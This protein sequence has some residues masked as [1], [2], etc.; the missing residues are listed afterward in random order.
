MINF[1]FTV[2]FLITFSNSNRQFTQKP[3][4][5]IMDMRESPKHPEPP[6]L[7]ELK[8]KEPTVIFLT[9]PLPRYNKIKKRRGN[10]ETQVPLSEPT[11][12]RKFLELPECENLGLVFRTTN[13]SS[14]SNKNFGLWC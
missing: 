14:Q 10:L 12:S 13:Q 2:R 8:K 7:S 11:D 6:K 1:G 4:F 9:K 5:W 3:K